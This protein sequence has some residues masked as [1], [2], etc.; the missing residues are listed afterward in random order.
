M[1]SCTM[2]KGRECGDC[3]LQRREHAEKR[4]VAEGK[5]KA[6]REQQLTI[7]KKQGRRQQQLG[8]DWP[9][10]LVERIVEQRQAEKE[11]RLEAKKKQSESSNSSS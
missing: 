9:A 8:G 2:A 10:C 6:E 3:G 1:R 4:G 5:E 7:L 11:E